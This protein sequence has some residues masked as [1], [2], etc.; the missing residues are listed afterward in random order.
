MPNGHVSPSH[1]SFR[2]SVS[3]EV[4]AWAGRVGECLKSQL[5][6]GGGGDRR[7][8]VQGLAPRQKCK[9]CLKNKL[10]HKGPEP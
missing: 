7:S 10:K 6:G 2:L 5:L 9:T 4:L 8:T 1:L 3:Q